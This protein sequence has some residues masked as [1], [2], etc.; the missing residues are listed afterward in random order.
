MQTNWWMGSRDDVGTSLECGGRGVDKGEGGGE[1]ARSSFCK[2]PEKC[3]ADGSYH[4]ESLQ[5]KYIKMWEESRVI[6]R[7]IKNM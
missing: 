3:G 2:H 5:K 4:L 1:G 6:D 7:S